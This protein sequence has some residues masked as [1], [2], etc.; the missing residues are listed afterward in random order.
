MKRL[1]AITLLISAMVLVG[2]RSA[3]TD[4]LKDLKDLANKIGKVAPLVMKDD[5]IGLLFAQGVEKQYSLDQ[6]PERN[7][8]VQQLGSKILSSNKLDG[9]YDFAVLASRDFNACSIYGGHVRV[10]EGLLTDTQNNDAEAAFVIAHEIAH[11]ELGHNK[12]A[13]KNF[14]IAKAI[15]LTSV[16]KNM[17]KLLILGA[18]AALAKR[19]RANESAADLQG[20]KYMAKAGYKITGA[21]AMAR[22]IEAEHTIAQKQAGSQGIAA[23]RFNAIFDTHPEPA[24]RAAMAEDELFLQKYGST[25]KQMAGDS[26]SEI[27]N[28]G[29]SAIIVAHPSLWTSPLEITDKD[30]VCGVG[31]FNPSPLSD[32]EQDVQYFLDL[33]KRRFEGGKNLPAVTCDNDSHNISGLETRGRF[34]FIEGDYADPVALIQ[35][36]KSGKTWASKNGAEIQT[37]NFPIGRDYPKVNYPHFTFKLVL[38]NIPLIFPEVIVYRDGEYLDAFGAESC[39]NYEAKYTINDKEAEEGKHWYIL[40]VKNQLITSPITLDVTKNSQDTIDPGGSSHWQ[41]GIIHFHS[42]YSDGNASL[43]SIWEAACKRGVGFICMTDHADCFGENVQHKTKVP[44]HFH[45]SPNPYKDF[46]SGCGYMSKAMMP[47]FEFTLTGGKNRHLL[48]LNQQQDPLNTLNQVC[49]IR[50]QFHLG[51]DISQT[52][53]EKDALFGF[54]K[55]AATLKMWIKGS[56]FK[57][58]IIWINR[59]EVGRVITTDNQWHLFTFQVPADYLNNGQNLYHMESFIPD[60]WHTFDDCEVKDIWIVKN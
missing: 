17:P 2:G 35:S 22:R 30:K 54:G 3:N 36:L 9:K 20:I 49:I 38:K 43:K 41:K 18:N 57:D 8:K 52:E 6:N 33:G 39:G 37:M 10:N 14:K 12:E 47:G 51:D 19:S 27:G 23:Q 44:P 58:P 21:I 31:I 24:K 29:D 28:W 25:F 53:M 7:T 45:K 26:T 15:E 48:I 32:E 16:T 11:N 56:P 1:F 5:A 50:D 59:H 46:V 42:Y 40:R 13:V 34:T 55:T 60:R 4:I